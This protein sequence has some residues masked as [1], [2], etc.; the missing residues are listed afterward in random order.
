MNR[1]VSQTARI[2][3][4]DVHQVK[5]WAWLFKEHLSRQANPAKGC[6]RTFTDSD[7]LALM[8]VVMHGKHQKRL[9]Q[10]V[11]GMDN[12]VLVTSVLTL[13]VAACLAGLIPARR[14]ASTDPT[15]A[16]RTE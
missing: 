14:A 8:H 16:L 15:Q 7:V 1:T 12:G 6:P 5:T 3:G 2:L 11:K 10:R 4:V 13:A 9:E